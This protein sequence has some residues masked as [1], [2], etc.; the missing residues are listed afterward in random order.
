M[1]GGKNTT[2]LMWLG[3]SMS[4][5]SSSAS[6]ELPDILIQ[7]QPATSSN[8]TKQHSTTYVS[9]IDDDWNVSRLRGGY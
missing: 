5:A 3:S 4:A 9:N 6:M 7:P 8:G 1:S 2:L